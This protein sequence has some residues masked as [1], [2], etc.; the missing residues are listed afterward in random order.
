MPL[1]VSAISI[2]RQ[3]RYDSDPQESTFAASEGLMIRWV[4]RQMLKLSSHAS[5]FGSD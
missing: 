4:E 2:T 5:T 1:P 3:D